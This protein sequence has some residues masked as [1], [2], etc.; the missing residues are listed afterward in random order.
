MGTP[1]EVTMDRFRSV[2]ANT[3][4]PWSRVTAAGPGCAGNPCDP[5]A[6]QI[7]WGADRLTYYAEQATWETPLLCYDQEMH[8]T[9]AEQHLAQIINE[10]LRPNTSNI[11]AMFAAQARVAVGQVSPHGQ[12]APELVQLPVESGC[13]RQR[14]VY[15]DC[16]ASPSSLFIWCP[17]CC[18]TTSPLPCAKVTRARIHSRKPSPFIELVTDMDTCWFL[19]KLGANGSTLPG[20]NTATPACQLA[21]HR[22]ERGQCVLALRILRPDR[23]LPDA[24]G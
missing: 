7:G 11:F 4:K 2:W 10:I 8:V 9:A 14:G 20:G 17:R 18:R 3:T 15:F 12:R 1:S 23:Q 24:R 21:F 13:Q 19:D 6:N 16:S 22:M 5:S